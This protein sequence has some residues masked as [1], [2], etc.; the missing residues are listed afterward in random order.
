LTFVFGCSLCVATSA[1]AQRLPFERSFDVGAAPRLDVSTMRGKIDITVGEPGR[2]VVGGAVTVRVAWD[3][4]ANAVDIAR[5]IADSP[6]I[7]RDGSTIRLRPPAERADQRAVTIN[8][9]VRVPPDTEVISISDSGATSVDGVQGSVSVRTQS[10]AIELNRLGGK[11]EVTTGS[12][13]VRVDTIA[14]GLTVKT[15]SS[16]ISAEAIGGTVHVRTGSGAVDLGLARG[17]DVDVETAS[18]AIRVRGAKG[19]LSAVTQSGRITIEGAPAAAWKISTGSG[20]VDLSLG[21]SGFDVDA[22]SR[23]GSVTVE[24]ARPQGSVS[25]RRVAGKIRGGGSLISVESRSG[26]IRFKLP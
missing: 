22:S 16:A 11:T 2:I 14:G 5:K 23:S 3:V 25:Q 9:Q 13:A 10:G 18:S 17:G 24:G 26:S 7:E 4:P 19:S 21:D 6:P 1:A 8:Y 20:G 15:A 12:G